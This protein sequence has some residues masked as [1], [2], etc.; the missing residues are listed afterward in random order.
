MTYPSFR[1]LVI[2]AAAVAIPSALSASQGPE[3]PS[4][5][6]VDHAA[7]TVS[8]SIVAG[9]TPANN[10]WNLN[11]FATGEATIVVPTGYAVEITYENA[12]PTMMVHS[13]GVGQV[14]ETTSAIFMDPAPV[15]EGAISS[16]PADPVNAT[17]SGATET[18]SFVADA[19]GDYA[20][21]C[22]VPGHTLTGMWIG[23][24]VSD[25]GSVGLEQ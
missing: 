5:M 15:F 14:S 19:A 12:D 18:L 10:N 6:T 17:K 2:T 3:I 22:Y 13:I 25:D 16:N 20:L 7:K 9:Q 24:R 21:I 1:S 23:F 4:W 11:G 8:M